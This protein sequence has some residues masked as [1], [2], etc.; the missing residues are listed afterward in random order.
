MKGAYVT[1]LYGDN[2]YFIGTLVFIV[3]L[4][5]TK[6][7]YDTLL[8]YTND[9]P[10]YK[11][12]MLE[13]YYTK[14]IPIEYIKFNDI[15]RK[16]F[17]DVYT[18]LQIFKLIDYDKILFMDNDMLVQKNIDHLFNYQAPAGVAISETLKYKDNELVTDPRVVF[19]AGLWLLKPSIDEFN[20]LMGGLENF[21]V[22]YELEQEYVS[23]Y[24]SGK[25]TN[26]SYLYNFQFSLGEIT[27]TPIRARAYEKVTV[28]EVYVIHY[29]A[30]KKPWD[31][32]YNPVKFKNSRYNRYSKY[33]DVFNRGKN[34]S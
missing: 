7:I 14:L 17:V 28:N 16:R 32:L 9:V 2:M 33:Y 31:V 1:L 20:K 13:K 23:Y 24:Y 21:N 26:I 18:K 27:K 22:S 19:N 6:P 12:D 34:Y 15:K 5:K 3:S 30:L 25:W 11:I 4:L 8:L 29:S 10:K